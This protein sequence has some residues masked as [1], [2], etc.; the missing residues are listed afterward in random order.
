MSITSRREPV[1]TRD[2]KVVHDAL[3]REFG[4]LPELIT[5]ARGPRVA[6]V[7]GH[8]RLLLDV[9][10][11]HHAGED[12]LLWPKLIAR[13][14]PDLGSTLKMAQRQHLDIHA[15][16][17]AIGRDLPA[18]SQDPAEERSRALADRIGALN[19]VLAEH[20][21]LEEREILP[22]AAR[23]LTASEWHEIGEAGAKAIPKRLAPIVFGMLTA[24]A[25]PEVTALMLASVPPGPR[26]LL[27]HTAARWHAAYHRRVYGSAA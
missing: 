11:H 16:T 17:E 13:A 20:L 4:S 8:A 15:H 14:E 21:D 3:R 7:H 1:D 24:D 27:R 9:L 5:T 23:E 10:D 18:W 19:T 26:F 6:I 25:P 12:R 22:V 2:M